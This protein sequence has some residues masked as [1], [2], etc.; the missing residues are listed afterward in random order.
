MHMMGFEFLGGKM[1]CGG[2]WDA[3]GVTFASKG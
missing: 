2:P 1:H 3:Y